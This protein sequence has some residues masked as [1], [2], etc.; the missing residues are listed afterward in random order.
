MNFQSYISSIQTAGESNIEVLRELFPTRSI[1][2]FINKP[3][4]IEY[5]VKRVNAELDIP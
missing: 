2:C 3:V 5:L 4:S 1:G